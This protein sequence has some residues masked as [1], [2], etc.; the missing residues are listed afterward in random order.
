[1][2]SEL[3]FGNYTLLRRVAA[4][5]CITAPPFESTLDR[6]G[7]VIRS[8]TAPQHLLITEQG[9]MELKMDCP[10][11]PALG[12]SDEKVCSRCGQEFPISLC[13]GEAK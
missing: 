3:S 9:M 4:G 13:V 11:F 1:M 8:D 5:E 12:K 7:L 2:V 10:P 6:Q